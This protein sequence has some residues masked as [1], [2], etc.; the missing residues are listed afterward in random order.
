VLVI[1]AAMAACSKR[2][3]TQGTEILSHDR[4]LVAQLAND[5]ERQLPLPA[6]CGT[7]PAVAQPAAAN[8]TQAKELTLQAQQA[9]LQGNIREASSMLRR[10]V[11][12]DG[13][14]KSAA[15]HLGLTSEALGERA[16]A[17]KAY[18]HYL[19][20]MPSTAESAEARQRITTLSQPETRVSAGNVSE[21][22]TTATT[23]RRGSAA[24]VRR[25]TR[26]R[27]T[28]EPRRVAS[29]AA[30]PVQQSVAAR[31]P[32]RSTTPASIPAS[33]ANESQKVESKPA[34]T[35][36]NVD[37]NAGSSGA[38]SDVVVT[39]RPVP[40]AEEPSTASSSVRR[41]P[42]RTQSAI[43]GAA[44]GAIIGAATGRSVK[45]AVI[46]AAAGG[47]LGTVVGGGRRPPVGPGFG[48]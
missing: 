34:T 37:A 42:S 21:S 31:S 46:G 38:E 35:S 29:A 43:M 13:T 36:A 33:G 48:S 47:I 18:C 39:S 25:V 5:H 41:G 17:L 28:P 14:N 26:E 3:D 9:E 32:E 8:Q 19:A 4:A 20:L 45:G 23:A 12:L 2:D 16:G 30:Q 22:T 44:G 6:S 1:F 11:E 10:A 15:Y 40:P 24:P 27:S 7:V